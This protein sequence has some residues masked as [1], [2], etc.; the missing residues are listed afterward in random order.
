[1]QGENNSL[2]TDGTFAPRISGTWGDNWT[3]D[4]GTFGVVVSGSFTEQGVTAFRPR[5]DRDNSVA[6]GSGA[7]SAQSFNFLPI[8]FLNQDYDNF[9]Y[10]TSNFAGSL[11]WAPNDDL[12]IY[13]DTV[14]NDQERG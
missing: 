3:T 5:T 12:T 14:I 11:E 1:M 10:E 13:L 8:Q 9:E 6:A 7:A 2:S 4:A